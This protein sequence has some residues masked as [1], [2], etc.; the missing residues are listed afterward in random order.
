MPW[1]PGLTVLLTLLILIAT[2]QLMAP[3]LGDTWFGDSYRPDRWEY[4]QRWVYLLTELVPVL[5]FAA[6]G[7]LFWWLGRGTRAETTVIATAEPA[8]AAEG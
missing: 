7:A 4:S 6:V 1:V 2:I 8:Q 3:G 5:C